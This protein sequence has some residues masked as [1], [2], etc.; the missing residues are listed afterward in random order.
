MAYAVKRI[1]KDVTLGVGPV[2][3]NGFF[4]D[5]DLKKKIS[6]SDLEKIESEMKKIIAEKLDFKKEVMPLK[7]AVKFFKEEGE[8]YKVELLKDLEKHG[9]TKIS[10]E[11]LQDMPEKV[12]EISIYKIGEFADLCRGPHVKNTKDLPSDS[13]K[14]TRLAGAYWRGDEKNP[15]L[16]RIYGIAFVNSKKLNE[17]LKLQ[18]EIE[19]RDHRKIGKK[20]DLFS[21]HDISPGSIFWHPKGMI[22]YKKLQEFIRE[23]N[24]VYGY[25]EVS[26]PVMVKKEL[27][28]T[29]GHWEHFRED[30]FWFDVDKETYILKPMNCPGGTLIY[31][32]ALRSYKDLPLRLSEPTGLIHR[33]E[34][35]GALGGLFRVR[36]FIQDDAHIFCRPDQFEKEVASLIKYTKEIYETFKMPIDFKFATKPDKAMGDPKLWE[37]AEKALETVLKKL[38]IKYELKPKDGAFYGPKIDIHAKDALGREHQLSTIQLDFQMPERFKL[39]YIDENGSKKRPI[40]IHRAILG[41]YER[42]IGVL[43]EHKNGALP[44]WLSPVQIAVISIS[45]KQKKSAE[46]FNK[47]LKDEGIRVELYDTDETISKRIREAEIQKIPYIVVIGE[48]E[49]KSKTVSVRKRERGDIGSMKIEKFITQIKQEIKNKSL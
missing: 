42:F 38:N 30:G 12:S 2:I 28:E 37:K 40:M 15:Q 49:V 35:K 16:Q 5:F 10:Q 32:N 8:K 39:E 3:E 25:D 26:T 31:S 41:A 33:N 47:S 20:L 18:K 48:K 4:Y 22:I 44:L 11:E 1:Y 21:F 13:F 24:E 45:E 23:K 46:E 14:L 36:Q 29:S 34:L 19:K 27:Y 9:T 43:L 7:D 6:D 17:Y